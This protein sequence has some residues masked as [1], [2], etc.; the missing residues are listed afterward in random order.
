MRK[1]QKLKCVEFPVKLVVSNGLFVG[2]TA[3]PSRESTM[4]STD[5]L[6][7]LGIHFTLAIWSVMGAQGGSP[8]LALLIGLQ[9]S[10]P[11]LSSREL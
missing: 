11:T 6:I 10:L 5:W 3:A 1:N 2:E 9:L 7:S 8:F 4:G